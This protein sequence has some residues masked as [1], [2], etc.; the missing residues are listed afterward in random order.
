MAGKAGQAGLHGQGRTAL[1]TRRRALALPPA[2]LAAPPA[3]A[4]APAGALDA[5]RRAGRLRV[6]VTTWLHTLP[7]PPAPSKAPPRDAFGEALARR[8]GELL[9]L[10]AEVEHLRFNGQSLAWLAE[11]LVD[12]AL[13]L[14]M[15]RPAAR[16]VM[17]AR[18]HLLLDSVVLA[19]AEPRQRRRLAE[20]TGAP[21][22]VLPGVVEAL[23][24][25][26]Q[27]VELLRLV[28]VESPA[29]L[30]EALIEGAAFGAILGAVQARAIQERHPARGWMIRTVLAAQPYAAAVAYGEH[31]L[32]RALDQ[33]MMLALEEGV[34]AHLFRQAHGLPFP[35]LP[36][37]R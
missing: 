10:R 37:A 36:G 13:P 23:E 29:A 16:A 30:E 27:P 18:P 25:L 19:P 5:A 24:D 26:G 3:L 11:G 2:L 8:L 1:C 9:N 28:P 4:S 22:A 31:D 32:L 21:L 14:P 12:F 17:F 6:G 20:W 15:T 34:V 35:P 7:R 33:A